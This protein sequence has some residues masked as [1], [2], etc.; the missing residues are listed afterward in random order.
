MYPCTSPFHRPQSR[1]QPFF[2][3]DLT[4]SLPS[5]V[6]GRR[7]AFNFWANCPRTAQHPP[8]IHPPS[9]SSRLDNGRQ[10]RHPA[11]AT[12]V[13]TRRGC[14]RIPGRVCQR[15]PGRACPRTPGR[16]CSRIPGRTRRRI[17]GRGLGAESPPGRG[18]E[19]ISRRQGQKGPEIKGTNIP[20]S[21]HTV[22][23]DTD[24]FPSWSSFSPP[25]ATC[26]GGRRRIAALA[27]TTFV[28]T[29]SLTRRWKSWI[30]S[31]CRGLRRWPRYRNNTRDSAAATWSG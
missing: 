9:I 3:A 7:P 4:F 20:P 23:L 10:H 16:A 15:I 24:P 8:S 21:R 19:K 29:R 13:P 28:G 14:Q 30:K 11:T 22:L 6:T 27:R 25:C 2:R 18:G 26:W 31:S 12:L 17:P 5:T 1:A